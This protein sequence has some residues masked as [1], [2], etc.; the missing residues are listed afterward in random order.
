MTSRVCLTLVAGREIEE[1]LFDH[2]W[3][4]PDLVSGFTASDAEGHGP[5]ARLHSAAEQVKGRADRAFVQIILDETAARQLISR[6][7]ELFAGSHLVY[8][9]T[10][11][12]SSGAI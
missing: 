11:V 7:E 6:L 1:E 10:P 12:L 2:L 9:T 8:W 4:Q 3:E 5:T